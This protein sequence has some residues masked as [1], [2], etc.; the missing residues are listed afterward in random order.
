MPGDKLLVLAEGGLQDAVV[1]KPAATCGNKYQLKV[2][3]KQLKMDLNE[4]NH[5][6]QNFGTSAVRTARR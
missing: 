1:V 5:C 6:K 2:G 4:Y 3:A